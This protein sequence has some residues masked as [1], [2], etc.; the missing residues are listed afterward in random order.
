MRSK[1]N[2][3]YYNFINYFVSSVIGKMDYKKKCCSN[4]LSTYA[5]VSDEAFALLSFEN[6]FDTWMDMGVRGDT[7]T[8][9]VPRKYTNGGKLQNKTATSQHNKGWSDEGLQRF[10]VL[11]DL[12]E[13]NR[14]S[15]YAKQFEEDLRKWCEAKAEG[16]KQKKVEKLLLNL[17]KCVMN[18]GVMMRMKIYPLV[19]RMKVQVIN[20][21]KWTM[22]VKIIH[23]P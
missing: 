12:V 1:D 16:K 22:V 13:K 19:I 21:L 11:F 23:L 20:G 8:S 3:M 15:P 4:L 2:F 18:C 7:K 10:N 14:A 9:Q 6:N 5:T 17:F